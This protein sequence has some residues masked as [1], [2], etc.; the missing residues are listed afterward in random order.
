MAG[1]PGSGVGVAS[2]MD[3]FR[4]SSLRC[5]ALV[6]LAFAVAC[7]DA[8]GPEEAATPS[9]IDVSASALRAEVEALAH[10]SMCGRLVGTTYE[11]QAATYIA[12][13]FARAGLEAGGTDG[14][15][16]AVPI[17]PPATPPTTDQCAFE[18]TV[19]SQNVIATLPGVGALAGEWVVIGAHFDHLGWRETNGRTEVFNGADD[20][21]SGTAVVLE[22]ARLLGTWAA[23]HPDAVPARRSIMFQ[24]YGA[25]EIGLY[26]SR[27]FA[28]TPT[29]PGDSV[30]AMVNLDMV[31]MLRDGM[32]TIGGAGTSSV[33]SRLLDDARSDGVTFVFN[34][35]ALD[36]SDQ[37]SFISFLEVP[38][39]HLFTGLEQYYHTPADDPPLLNYDGMSRVA[40]LALGLLW[41]L[42][43]RPGAM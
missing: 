36:R 15:Y 43:T 38:A 27:Q 11:R 19:G 42:A 1:I 20:N 6:P 7:S 17:G 29:V 40:R 39:V 5:L 31:G 28:V 3:N 10:D 22:V 18:A 26:G 25:E 16:Q 2:S 32:L 41:D 34:D 33:W 9:E 37:W 24:T 14:Y 30:Y 23:A 35:D 12:A 4:S 21:A 8:V 13:R